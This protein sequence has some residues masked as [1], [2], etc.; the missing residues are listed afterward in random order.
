MSDKNFLSIVFHATFS[1]FQ[2]SRSCKYFK[3]CFPHFLFDRPNPV[4]Q[5]KYCFPRD[6][7]IFFRFQGIANVPSYVF[8]TFCLIYPSM[9]DKSFL[10]IVFHAACHFFRFQ[11]IA[12]IP[13]YVFHTFCLI[14]QALSDE[15]FLSIGFPATCHFFQISRNC[16]YSKLCFPHF[17]FDIPSSIRRKNSNNWFPQDCNFFQIYVFHTFCLIYPA[18]S[19][20][21]SFFWKV[22]SQ[23][24]IHC[25]DPVLR[26]GLKPQ[27]KIKRG[28]QTCGPSASVT[29][30]GE[31]GWDLRKY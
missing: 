8:H 11:G 12:N 20:D 28:M 9:S 15:K 19:E 30:S 24:F 26:P 25:T 18:L 13:S 29:V 16:K 6:F 21:L 7:F 17:L 1:F 14:Y 5:K 3:L 22:N 2:I 31:L 4:R 10:S 27:V 23:N